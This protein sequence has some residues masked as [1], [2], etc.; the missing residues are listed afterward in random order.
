ML[1][2]MTVLSR[3]SGLLV[4]QLDHS[5]FYERRS[6]TDYRIHLLPLEGLSITYQLSSVL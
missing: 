5:S 2:G 4:G 6:S 1:R 3:A